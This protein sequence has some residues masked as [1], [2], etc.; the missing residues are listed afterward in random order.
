MRIVF[1]PSL[2]RGTVSVRRV[3][4]GV[5]VCSIGLFGTGARPG[6]AFPVAKLRGVDPVVEIKSKKKRWFVARNRS[7]LVFGDH[8]RTG[9]SGAAEVI[10]GGNTSLVLR[11]NTEI[12]ITD[13]ET[14]DKPLVVRLIGALGEVVVRSK[15]RTEIRTAAGIAATIGTE[16][17]V[18]LDAENQTTVTV[19]EGSVGFSN[20]QGAVVVNPDQQSTARVGTAPT[21]PVRVDATG[22]LS[23]TADIAGL[24]VP[25][26]FPGNAADGAA[27][28]N[29]KTLLAQGN[30]NGAA[31]AFEPLV[32]TPQ[33][34]EAR[35][36]LALARLSNRDRVG[37]A[38]AVEG[39]VTPLSLGVRALMLL[40]ENDAR[41]AQ[42]LLEPLAATPAAPFQ[43]QTL[44]AL[45]QIQNADVP[46][47]IRSATRAVELA[48]TSAGALATLSLAQFFA[49]TKG[50]DKEALRNARRAV[51]LDPFS[52]LALLAVGRVE[53][54]RGN[55]DEARQALEQVVLLSPNLP[56]AQRDLGAIELS[57]DRLP[58]AEKA[59]RASLET[60]PNDAR[61]LATLGTVQLKRGDRAGARV[62]LDRA[63][64]LAP[65]DPFVRANRAA[66]LVENGD[67]QDAAREGDL[68]LARQNGAGTP[69]P[70][71][72][73]LL[74]D[75]PALGAL[76]IRLSES[77]LFRQQLN[78]SMRYARAAVKLLPDSSTA[79]YQLGRV[80]LEQGRTTQAQNRFQLASI[81]DP[82]SARAR[83][84]L[85]YAQEL[86]AQGG[87]VSRPLGQ[88]QGAREAAPAGALTLQNQA[89]PGAF[90]RFQAAIQDPT[91]VRSATRSF[92]D[93]QL[94][95]RLGTDSTATG[96]VSYAHESDD[97]RGLVAFGLRRDTTAGARAAADSQSS[98]VAVTL[99]QKAQ[100]SQSALFAFASFERNNPSRDQDFDQ[101][102]PTFTTRDQRPLI[103]LGANFADGQNN[104]T[105]ILVQADRASF[106]QFYS[107][108]GL[109]GDYES[110]HAEVRHDRRLNDQWSLS[111]GFSTGQRRYDV[112]T[113]FSFG[114]TTF[115]SN[116][117][118]IAQNNV[119][120]TRVA[121]TPSTKLKLEG[122]L[123]I[124]SLSRQ[125]IAGFRIEPSTDPPSPPFT[126]RV[127]G[128]ELLP[129]V[130]GTYQAGP[131]TLL[132]FR[133]R[134][135]VDGIEDFELL[136]PTDLFGFYSGNDLPSLDSSST[137]SGTL[138]GPRGKLYEFELSHTFSN[139][140]FLRVGLF[141]SEQ[142]RSSR[143]D[144]GEPFLN[145]RVQGLRV[146]YEGLIN[147]RTSF[148]T[149]ASWNGSRALVYD[150]DLARP[151]SPSTV[152]GLPD[153]TGEAGLQYL[154]DDGIFIQPSIA[155][156]GPRYRARQFGTGDFRQQFGGFS[157]VNLRVGKRFGLR[158]SFYAEVSNLFDK[159]Y[160]LPGGA[161]ERL[162]T[163]RQFR[164]G[165]TVRF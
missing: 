86:V 120:Y 5:F 38:A 43:I 26:E 48:P 54:T 53:A 46:G 134:R 141:R 40:E 117:N 34:D 84:A 33:A 119:A 1:C 19:S 83:Y 140:S 39:A 4:S 28:G 143:P 133:A 148:F 79:Q 153:Y 93:W 87:D 94:D 98:R 80:F 59:L 44:L 74:T 113:D 163:G 125:A 132:R 75:N 142:G 71:N 41:G 55:L 70:A 129:T 165:A 162:Q 138:A 149:S 17:S 65:E 95:G 121:F 61:T 77:A 105:R 164:V 31:A 12:H 155:Y 16:Y 99:G 151:F 42:N 114:D 62:S 106:D 90:E 127:E 137:S 160:T 136:S 14:P 18:R 122:E 111:A 56:G 20:P 103:V 7:A 64:E 82:N 110:L 128:G 24:P 144:T 126:Q 21:P 49:Q 13:P 51:E 109:S 57:L 3:I 147:T 68:L 89:T 36:G 78:E 102:S 146:G 50:A 10:F 23:W 73:P 52:P 69:V 100:D 92:G 145:S 30:A 150:P 72:V 76:Y 107:T 108:G 101:P 25:F 45:A 159:T 158:R 9:S 91:V 27:L 22:L 32:N 154:S 156:V 104:R 37:A 88:T 60:Q 96:E 124:R 123:K 135:I 58:R 115:I 112:V 130:V 15:G 11:A 8:V 35:A 29:A 2:L 157:L 85:G 97:R 131:S 47:A 139:S 63:V 118:A 6:Y 67:L 116:S 152:S 161:A 66:F 81:L